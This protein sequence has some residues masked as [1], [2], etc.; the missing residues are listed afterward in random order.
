MYKLRLDFC[1]HKIDTDDEEDYRSYDI[2]SDVWYVQEDQRRVE[3]CHN[4]RRML[5]LEDRSSR[6]FLEISNDIRQFFS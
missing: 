5:N 1:S 2:K 4:H 3:G 6:R